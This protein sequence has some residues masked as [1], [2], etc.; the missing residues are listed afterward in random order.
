MEYAK[1]QSFYD[2]KDRIDPDLKFTHCDVVKFIRDFLKEFRPLSDM[3]ISDI[4]KYIFRV[5]Q[6][7]EGEPAA[8]PKSPRSPKSE[9]QKEEIL[10][11]EGNEEVKQDPLSKDAD[12]NNLTDDQ[13][14]DEKY[15]TP[16]EIKKRFLFRCV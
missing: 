7:K 5:K 3:L 10:Q 1:Q 14:D 2:E 9:E 15:K 16:E 8:S 13:D 11:T 6:I 12:D 4:Y